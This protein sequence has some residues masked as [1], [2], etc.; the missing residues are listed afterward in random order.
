MDNCH[1][2]HL[3]LIHTL[4]ILLLWRIHNGSSNISNLLLLWLMIVQAFDWLTVRINHK[5]RFI[6]WILYLWL[7]FGVINVSHLSFVVLI[8]VMSLIVL[9]LVIITLTIVIWVILI[10]VEI[11]ILLPIIILSPAIVLLII[12][13]IIVFFLI[14]VVF[15]LIA[16]VVRTLFFYRLLALTRLTLCSLKINTI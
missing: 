8:I 16:R 12:I 7:L 13:I 1:L 2:R 3:L 15:L 5:Y 6:L 10:V 9:L 11:I 14:L 4:I